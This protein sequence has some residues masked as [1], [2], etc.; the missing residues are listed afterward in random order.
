MIE[1]AKIA[2]KNCLQRNTTK[3]TNGGEAVRMVIEENWEKEEN[4]LVSFDAVETAT[5][6]FIDEAIAK[7]LNTHSLDELKQ[8]LRFPGINDDFKQKINKSIYLRSIKSDG[9]QE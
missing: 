8:K 4:I 9:K 5:S 6:S 7:L 2:G 1:V 3:E